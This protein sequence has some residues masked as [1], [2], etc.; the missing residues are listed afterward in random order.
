MVEDNCLP[1]A[2]TLHSG[3]YVPRFSRKLLASGSECK[4]ETVQKKSMTERYGA[5][6]SELFHTECC[7]RDFSQLETC[8]EIN[9]Y[10]CYI[11]LNS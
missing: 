8:F 10:K 6:I 5:E 3:T 4:V 11:W 1:K 7:R 2:D 9:Y